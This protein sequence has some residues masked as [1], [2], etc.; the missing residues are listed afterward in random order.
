M[1][2]AICVAGASGGADKDDTSSPQ[3]FAAQGH[4][5]V[6]REV[7]ANKCSQCHAPASKNKHAKKHWKDWHDLKQLKINYVL[8]NGA[9]PDTPQDTMLWQIITSDDEE[10]HMPPKKAKKGQLSEDEFETIRQWLQAGAP[11]GYQ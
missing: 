6:V 10:I 9:M 4:A 7:F 11:T 2:L 3:P 1:A 8:E 5:R